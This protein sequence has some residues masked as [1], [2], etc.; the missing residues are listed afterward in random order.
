MVFFI[1]GA[2]KT[3][4]QDSRNRSDRRQ[5]KSNKTPSDNDA[6][7]SGRH[8]SDA[9]RGRE[10]LILPSDLQDAVT[11]AL[12]LIEADNSGLC[13][14]PYHQGGSQRPAVV[15]ENRRRRN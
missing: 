4:L 1:A 11:I 5:R 13:G 12:A 10:P 7:A 6:I 3:G 15:A 8:E 2:G 9:C 14:A